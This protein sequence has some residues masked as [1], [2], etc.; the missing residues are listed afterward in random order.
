MNKP[1]QRPLVFAVSAMALC[2]VAVSAFAAQSRPGAVDTTLKHL[3]T[4]AIKA[5]GALMDRRAYDLYVTGIL[6]ENI[7]DLPSAIETYKLALQY[8]PESYEI[9]FS[10]AN[11]LVNTHRPD[12]ALDILKRLLPRDA[13]VYELSATC[14]RMKGDDRSAIDSYRKVIALDTTNFLAY[15]VLAGYFQVAGD[16]D[17]TLWA[18][19]QLTRIRPDNYRVWFEIGR[20]R[21]LKQ[22]ID[23][24]KKALNLSLSIEDGPENTNTLQ[25]LGELYTV[26]RQL[27]SAALI[28]KA[29]LEHDRANIQLHNK[30]I[31]VYIQQDSLAQALP[32]AK[33]VA[34]INPLDK[35]SL[36]RLGILYFSL[37]SIPAADSIFT[38]LI[39]SGDDSPTDLYYMGRIAGLRK[40][41]DKAIDYFTKLTQAADTA[42][43][44]WYSLG[45]VYR[46][47]GQRDK[48]I[49]TYRTG[50]KHMRSEE[51]AVNLYFALGASQEQA[52]QFDSSVSTFEELLKHSPDHSQALNYLGYMLADKGV[53]LDY[54]KSL[55][56]RAVALAPNTPAFLDSYGW[57]HFRLGNLEA[58]LQ[59]LNQA[60]ELDTDVTIF[61]HLGDVY[62]AQGNIE[63]ARHWWNRA[64]E[65]QPDNAAIR[66]KLVR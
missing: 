27:D 23:G 41:Y 8:Y 10:L 65:V 33:F 40:D 21:A 9:G 17:S 43:G 31:G 36:R 13:G 26:G 34:D 14:Y 53:R 47:L 1:R 59:Y 32:H 56:E 39:K 35:P 29:G 19:E 45:Y 48:E 57:V 4:I 66:Q 20:V 15:S 2:L 38:S 50:I 58:A 25:A 12:D 16:I 46:D 22:D 28:Y 49:E 61:D 64:L 30:L 42:I 3:P 54:A 55:I 62:N 37:D 7:G 24:A 5:P 6:Q 63:Q 44:S 60:A 18:Y 11:V 52:G 51:N